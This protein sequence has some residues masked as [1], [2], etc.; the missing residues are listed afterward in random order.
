MHGVKL[1]VSVPRRGL[2]RI[3]IIGLNVTVLE[4]DFSPHSKTWEWK[5]WEADVNVWFSL[6]T[7]GNIGAVKWSLGWSVSLLTQD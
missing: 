5:P 1:S 3:Y 2:R 6:Y 7:D 4:P